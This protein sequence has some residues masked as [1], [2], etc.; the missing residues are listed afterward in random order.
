MNNATDINVA[1][2][3]QRPLA[4]RLNLYSVDSSGV[5]GKEAAGETDEKT[6]SSERVTISREAYQLKRQYSE[7]KEDLR[8]DYQQDKQALKREYQQEKKRIEQEYEQ[9][10][11]SLDINVYA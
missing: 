6:D 5:R 1:Q 10:K 7:K 2:G 3:Y 9:K 8:L 11:E 4:A